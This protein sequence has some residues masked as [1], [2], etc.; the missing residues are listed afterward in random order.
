M[1]GVKANTC[2]CQAPGLAPIQ[3]LPGRWKDL[4]QQDEMAIFK[5]LEVEKLLQ[6]LLTE[7]QCCLLSSGQIDRRKSSVRK[8]GKTGW[9]GVTEIRLMR[10]WPIDVED[11]MW[12]VSEKNDIAG[13]FERGRGEKKNR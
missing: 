6:S 3:N 7:K 5:L 13:I 8:T 4:L 1:L 9:S 12:L 2:H 10:L 11:I